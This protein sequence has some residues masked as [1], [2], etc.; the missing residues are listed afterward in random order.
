MSTTEKV[1][2]LKYEWSKDGMVLTVSK[3]DGSR[4]ERFDTREVD[5][6]LN[7]EIYNLGFRTKLGYSAP[8]KSDHD[9]KLDHF[10]IQMAELKDGMWEREREKMPSW[11][12]T[13]DARRIIEA[14]AAVHPNRPTEAAVRATFLKLGEGEMLKTAKNP[15]VAAKIKELAAAGEVDLT[16]F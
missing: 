16:T 4:T 14:V 2:Q 3:P 6:D 10:V 15:K 9:A 12:R 1:E 5:P 8:A 11:I 13:S 7:R